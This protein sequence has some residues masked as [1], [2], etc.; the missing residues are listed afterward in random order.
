MDL[1]ESECWNMDWT[2]LAQDMASVRMVNKPSGITNV[3]EY[4]DQL[5]GYGPNRISWPA[6]NFVSIGMSVCESVFM[7]SPIL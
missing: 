7:Q 6:L 4:L 1:K 2:H 5:S 3:R